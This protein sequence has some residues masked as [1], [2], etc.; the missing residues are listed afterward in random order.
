MSSVPTIGKGKDNMG[1]KILFICFL[2]FLFVFPVVVQADPIGK[3]IFIEGRVDITVPG[4]KARPAN[5]GDRVSPGDII[6]TK[7]KS[8]MQ[9]TFVDGS[10]MRFAPNTRMKITEYMVEKKRTKGAFALFRGKIQ[11][12]VK[13]TLGRLFGFGRRNRIEVRTPTAVCGVR[14][15][16]FFAYHRK[17]IS[18]AVFKEGKGYGYSI[19]RPDETRTIEAGQAML[20][21]DPNLPPVLR[22]VTDVEMDQ[23]LSDT[24]SSGKGQKGDEDKGEEATETEGLETE[25]GDDSAGSAPV[26]GTSATSDGSGPDEDTVPPPFL[27]PEPEYT[28]ELT[29]PSTP[30]FYELFRRNGILGIKTPGEEPGFIEISRTDR[31]N[32]P[33]EEALNVYIG[34]P[35]GYFL[36]GES[37]GGS[38]FV[39]VIA[40]EDES[41]QGENWGK[42]DSWYSGRYEEYNGTTYDDWSLSRSYQETETCRWFSN[43]TGSKWSEDENAALVVE[44]RVASAWVNWDECTT[45]IAGG[46]IEGTYDPNNDTWEATGRQAWFETDRFMEMIDSQSEDLQALEIPCVE[47]GKVNLTGSGNNMVVNMNDVTFFSYSTGSDPKIWATNNV[48]GAYTA[49][50]QIGVSVPLSGGGLSADFNVRTWGNSNWGANI[51]NG[52]GIL[53]RTDNGS[54]ID[55]QF[56]GGAAGT[57]DSGNFSGTGAGI[58]G[59]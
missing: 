48:T 33:A 4:M 50:P 17:N 46:E 53:N 24:C 35:S 34:N 29:E 23:H 49:A 13:T 51:D 52:Q 5:L 19:N 47:I 56:S 8:R 38:I 7:S 25:I 1:K 9:I 27:P 26:E 16:N 42:S 18:G 39:N 37:F 43:Y 12:I 6:R 21:A 22:R 57:Y 32:L 54:T 58:A 40:R 41:Y 15:T 10:I 20:V 28:I 2:A 30:W 59:K 3:I 14:G 11:C 36:D 44:A 31:D 45:G 55:L